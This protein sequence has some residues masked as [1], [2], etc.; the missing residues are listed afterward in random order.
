MVVTL[1]CLNVLP[2]LLLVQ[3][4][5]CL[6]PQQDKKQEIFRE[7]SVRVSKKLCDISEEREFLIISGNV[8]RRFYVIFVERH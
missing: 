8:F 4:N 6:S 1:K 5:F 7:F 2:Q 3:E